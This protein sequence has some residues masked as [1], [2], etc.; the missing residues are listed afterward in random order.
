MV[1]ESATPQ[2]L[3]EPKSH[4]GYFAE[5]Y[6]ASIAAAAGLDVSLP[7]LGVATDLFV[8]TPGPY[9]TSSSRQIALQVKSWSRP[10]RID[11]NGYF[12]YP[13]EVSAYNRLAGDGHDVRHFL[14]LCIVPR[15]VDQYA[16]ALH[17]RLSLKH[18]V[19]WLSLRDKKPDRTLNDNSR[20]TVL[21][22]KNHL[23]T[24]DTIRALVERREGMAIVP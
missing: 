18:A 6:V 11:S 19:Y 15:K 7:R 2:R 9:G 14:I 4:Q 22:P 13:L 17:S 24:P 3:L 10:T 21:V 12:H 5:A 1:A 16:S 8:Y 23:I 20:K